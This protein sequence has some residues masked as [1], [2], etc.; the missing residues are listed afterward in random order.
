MQVQSCESDCSDQLV[1]DGHPTHATS[2]CCNHC[3]HILSV[4]H[5]VASLHCF[6]RSSAA[7]SN[8]NSKTQTQTQQPTSRFFPL[9]TA[10]CFSLFH[11]PPI[12]S[13]A[14]FS[15]HNKSTNLCFIALALPACQSC[16]LQAYVHPHASC[17]P[18]TSS[19]TVLQARPKT[20]LL[21]LCRMSPILPSP[22]SGA[23]CSLL[24]CLLRWKIC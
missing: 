24:R 16:T 17:S 13:N 12:T 19:S 11:H 5:G 7:R 10:T 6:L 1:M 21:L 22:T 23:A 18:R 3:L 2:R 14:Y 9:W 15:V 4:A 8:Q 20:V